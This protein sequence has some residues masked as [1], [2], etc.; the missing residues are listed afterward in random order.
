MVARAE[1]MVLRVQEAGQKT[2][3]GSHRNN[4]NSTKGSDDA[5]SRASTRTLSTHQLTLKVRGKDTRSPVVAGHEGHPPCNVP[6]GRESGSARGTAREGRRL[7]QANQPGERNARKQA[8]K[9]NY[10]GH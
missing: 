8:H 5:R 9:D 2:G 6:G 7:V 4:A 10:G 3:A 1:E